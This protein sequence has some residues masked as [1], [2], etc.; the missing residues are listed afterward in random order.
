L[1]QE[2]I[3]WMVYGI[4]MDVI[5]FNASIL[6]Q[7]EE[8]SLDCEPKAVLWKPEKIL[9]EIRA[10]NVYLKIGK[11]LYL[12]QEL[13]SAEQGWTMAKMT[14]PE[15][16]IVLDVSIHADQLILDVKDRG[17]YQINA[18]N[19]GP[20]SYAILCAGMLCKRHSYTDQSPGWARGYSTALLALKQSPFGQ[21][22]KN[23]Q[24]G[25][26]R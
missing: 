17:K 1:E 9:A 12:A 21:V 25:I 16:W 22:C 13:E 24:C 19:M 4:D 3:D 8:Q 11:Y 2:Q 6:A 23:T 20:L 15:N 26:L 10:D 5:R 7:R 14:I 18:L